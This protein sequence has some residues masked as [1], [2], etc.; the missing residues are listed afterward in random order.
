MQIVSLARCL[1]HI[2]SQW[3]SLESLALY[4]SG[5]LHVEKLERM[6]GEDEGRG[7]E[8]RSGWGPDVFP[9]GEER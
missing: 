5:S 3:G 9:V 7:A 2:E 1:S 8:G 4:L 6:E